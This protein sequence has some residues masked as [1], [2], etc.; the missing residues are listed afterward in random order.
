[1]HACIDDIVYGANT[2]TFVYVCI[3][4]YRWVCGNV[5]AY[6]GMHMCTYMCICVCTH[7]QPYVYICVCVYVC[8]FRVCMCMC[9][10]I[11]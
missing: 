2:S 9:M 4:V 10:C 5:H 8:V 7:M 6:S 11:Y 1:M 3:L